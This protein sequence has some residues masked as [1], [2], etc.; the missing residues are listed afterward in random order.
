MAYLLH[1]APSGERMGLSLARIYNVI[2]LWTERGAE[3]YCHLGLG[4]RNL[5]NASVDG[6]NVFRASVSNVWWRKVRVTSRPGKSGQDDPSRVDQDVLADWQKRTAQR[7][8]GA[9]S[10]AHQQLSVRLMDRLDA[11]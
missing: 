3:F 2:E 9:H 11:A 7:C 8:S 4:T 1:R 5:R 10:P 6:R